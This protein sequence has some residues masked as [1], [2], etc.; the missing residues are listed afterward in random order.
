MDLKP[1]KEQGMVRDMVRR[2]ADR[3]LKPM[4]AQYDRT[5]EFPWEHVK[6]LGEMGMMGVV[7]PEEYNGAASHSTTRYVPKSRYLHQGA[8]PLL[9]QPPVVAKFSSVQNGATYG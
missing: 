1:T 6:K 4:A 5:H 3:S 9:L 2:F 7:Y 8:V